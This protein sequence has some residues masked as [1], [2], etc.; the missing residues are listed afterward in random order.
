MNRLLLSSL[1]RRIFQAALLLNGV[2]I[3][4]T[5]F[6]LFLSASET[7]VTRVEE[8]LARYWRTTYDIVVRPPGYRS[9][10]E[11]E[12]QLVQ[13]NYLLSIPGG[14]TFAQYEAIRSIPGVEVAA[15]VATLGYWTIALQQA[16]TRS[17]PE[18]VYALRCIQE[19]D[20]GLYVYRD[21][22]DWYYLSYSDPAGELLRIPLEKRVGLIPIPSCIFSLEGLLAGV[23]PDAE[24]TLVGLSHALLE[25][26]IMTQ[27]RTTS[28]MVF[29]PVIVNITP[30]VSF[31]LTVEA[32]PV[33]VPPETRGIN[34]ILQQGG[35]VYLNTLPRRPLFT[36]ETR[37]AEEVYPELPRMIIQQVGL[38]SGALHFPKSCVQYHL[39]FSS[40]LPQRNSLVLEM[41]VVK[42]CEG[43]HRPLRPFVSHVV[44][45]FRSDKLG[46]SAEGLTM[47]PL[48]LYFPP[49]ITLLYDEN[50][51]PVAPKVIRPSTLQITTTLYFHPPPLLLTTLEAARAIAGDD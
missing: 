21:V 30:F 34:D 46:L 9:Q 11:E 12:Y 17:L 14:I 13:P 2:L 8:D 48:E 50:G 20:T 1:Q 41:E 38:A 32:I 6:V 39:L 4:S 51:T 3:V 22:Q 28:D 5:A 36:A 45:T 35:F 15:P 24:E 42:P 27:T 31:T 40:A 25:G 49:Q 19:E 43:V 10:V 37:I 23:D 16:I 26:S 18:G 44:G 47:V 29:V 33:E 7:T